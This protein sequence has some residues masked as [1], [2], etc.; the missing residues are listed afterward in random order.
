M[1]KA[2]TPCGISLS[3]VSQTKSLKKGLFGAL[4]RTEMCSMTLNRQAIRG[5]PY[6]SHMSML[7]T[8]LYE[9]QI[10]TRAR[11]LCLRNIDQKTY[12]QIKYVNGTTHIKN[13][14]FHSGDKYRAIRQNSKQ[15]N[16]Q[17]VSTKRAS[18][19]TIVHL[20][21]RPL[22]TFSDQSEYS[23]FYQALV[24]MK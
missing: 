17:L 9:A 10:D 20:V 5:K 18:Y 22:G 2:D 12:K 6:L 8:V 1:K 7:A 11:T 14:A 16:A 4:K 3:T 19:Y 24:N 15:A 23:R 13:R 21:R